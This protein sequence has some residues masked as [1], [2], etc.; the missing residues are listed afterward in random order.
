MWPPP[1]PTAARSFDQF[2]DA[3]ADADAWEFD[4]ELIPEYERPAPAW[5]HERST[6]IAT[7]SGVM[8]LLIGGLAVSLFAGAIEGKD[9][10]IPDRVGPTSL[11][12]MTTSTSGSTTTTTAPTVAPSPPTSSLPPRP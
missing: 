3:G 4:T 2:D 7:S 5:W 12:L 6:I 1:D 8:L 10:R 9:G 11:V